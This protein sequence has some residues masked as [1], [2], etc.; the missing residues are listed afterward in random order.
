VRADTGVRQADL[1]ARVARALPPGVEA[2][3]GQAL[4]AEQ[5]DSVKKGVGI[6]RSILLAFAFVAVFV[7]S[8]II[9]NTFSILVAQR[10]R[11]LAL[12]RALGASR[13]Q[14]LRSVVLEAGITGFVASLAGV[15]LGVLIAKGLEA[16]FAAI[17]LDLGST[18]LQVG[19]K[20]VLIGLAVGTAVTVA[21]SLVP[22]LRATRV[23]PVEALRDSAPAPSAVSARRIVSGLGLLVTGVVVLMLGLFVASS[24]QLQLTGSGALLTFIGVAVLAP[25]VVAPMMSV[26]GAP[27]ARV[28]GVPGRLARE[29]ARRN[30]RRTASTASALMIGVGLV[31]TFTVV[32]ASFKASISQVVD[33]SV[34]ADYIVAP[35][36][37]SGTQAL[38]AAVAERVATVPQAGVVSR[39][40]GGGFSHD[41]SGDQVIAIQP[42]TIGRVGIFPVQQGAPLSTLSPGGVAISEDAVRNQS[43]HLGDTIPMQLQRPGL[44]RQRV[45]TVYA[46]NPLLGDY[47]IALP[48]WEAGNTQVQDQVVL[49][50]ARDGVAPAAL[51]TAVD[52]AVHD[53][54]GVKVQT[55][56]E[57]RRAQGQQLDTLLNIM[58]ALVA[59]AILIALLG[60]VNTMAL[61]IVDRTREL[62]LIR[63]LGMTRGQTRRMVRWE[64]VLITVMGALLGLGVGVFLGWALVRAFASAGLDA[65][66]FAPGRLTVYIVLAFVAGL[67]AAIFPAR[68]ASRVDMLRAIATE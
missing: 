17:G 42:A 27:V 11:E 2:V 35:D 49:L 9:L 48:V 57:Y 51:R 62:G 32:A 46:R 19:P 59:F 38:P 4:A 13:G 8:F 20:V 56:A 44:H 40:S 68:R 67:G 26:L 39:V 25:V 7:G 23:S 30:P 31:T 55:N 34:V 18:P 5:S 43:L 64:T 15:A 16:L 3:T 52:A 1:R 10:Q 36:S 63:A 45:S 50:R 66:S 21:A 12:L 54:P 58:N 28:A 33:R 14:V 29:I 53:F 6:F 24:N 41:G 65:L 37:Q 61:S 60:V 47:V 22:A